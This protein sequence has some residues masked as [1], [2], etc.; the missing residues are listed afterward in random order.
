VKVKDHYKTLGVGR[1]ATREQILRARNKLL[2]QHHPDVNPH[3]ELEAKE[4]TIEIILAAEVLSDAEARA[5][6]DNVYDR[7]YGR[8]GLGEAWTWVGGAAGTEDAIVCPACAR[9]NYKSERHYCIFCGAGIGDTPKPFSS[10]AFHDTVYEQPPVEEY[11][12][13][14]RATLAFAA[15]ASLLAMFILI[16]KVANERFIPGSSEMALVYWGTFSLMIIILSV[17]CF[18]IFTK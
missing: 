11:R 9:Y 4:M 8:G 5:E 16:L 7:V 3:R 14:S 6:Y 12:F 13:A 18:I 1:G 17:A 15:V 2:K 10:P